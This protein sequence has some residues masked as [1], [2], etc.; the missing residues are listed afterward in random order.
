[1]KKQIYKRQPL[2]RHKN[3]NSK[4]SWLDFIFL[5]AGGVFILD[6]VFTLLITYRFLSALTLNR[7]SLFG[8]LFQILAFRTILY[9]IAE[10]SVIN[11]CYALLQST[12]DAFTGFIFLV[13]FSVYLPIIL[14]K[15]YLILFILLISIISSWL[16]ILFL[17][18]RIR[19]LRKSHYFSLQETKK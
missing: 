15:T 14:I 12:A 10:R 8:W 7:I 19:N 18:S 4:K 5:K 17:F 11:S 1:M 3:L 6:V 2:I 9:I 13:L 16:S